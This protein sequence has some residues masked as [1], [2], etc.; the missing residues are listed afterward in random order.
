MVIPSNWT[1]TVYTEAEACSALP[2]HMICDWGTKSLLF[3]ISRIT[4]SDD[5]QANSRTRQRIAGTHLLQQLEVNGSPL[6]R[7][8][9]RAAR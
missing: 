6:A 8:A 9:F 4:D 2:F 7:G 1:V 3:A 5:P